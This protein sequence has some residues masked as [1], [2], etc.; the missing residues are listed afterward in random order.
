MRASIETMTISGKTCFTIESG[1]DKTQGG[2]IV[3]SKHGFQWR[4]LLVKNRYVSTR[5][6]PSMTVFKGND[7]S[8][9]D[10]VKLYLEMCKMQIEV[11]KEVE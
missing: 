7:S 10:C 5:F 8:F 3:P 11:S 4:L 1:H 2:L 9:E 6:N